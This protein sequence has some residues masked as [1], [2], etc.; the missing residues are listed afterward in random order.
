M[1]FNDQTGKKNLL[2][3]KRKLNWQAVRALLTLSGVS[4][5]AVAASAQSYPSRPVRIV[6]PLSSG[7][8]TDIPGRII[9]QRLTDVF[10]QQFL[11]KIAPALGAPL[12]PI[13]WPSPSQMG[14]PC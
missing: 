7:G 6:I 11:L 5:L 1:I 10:G 8:T 14:T 3:V 4:L 13:L 2:S 9:A 12:V